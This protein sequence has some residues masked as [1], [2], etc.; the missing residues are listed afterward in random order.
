MPIFTRLAC[1]TE[2]RVEAARE[3]DATGI[4]AVHVAARS[5]YYRGVLP[6]AALARSNARDAGQYADLVRR[7]DRVVRVARLGDLLIGFLMT[8]PCHHFEPDPEV[9]AELHQ[10][11]VHPDFHRLGVGT[12]LHEDAVAAWRAAG[13]AAA[14]L[15]AWDFNTR[16][17]A[18]YSR[19]GWQRDG[20]RPPDEPRI[21]EHRMLGYLLDLPG[22][23][24]REAA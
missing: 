19:H 3:A 10:I 14:R 18:F 13:V 15:W 20:R 23:G 24:P 1:V 17:R 22:L 9:T 12:A 6:E 21:G 11:H 8:G 7:P 2:V 5:S 16:A 4:R